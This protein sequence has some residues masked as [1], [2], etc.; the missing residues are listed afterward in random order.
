MEKGVE[1]KVLELHKNENAEFRTGQTVPH[2]SPNIRESCMLSVEGEVVGFYLKETP[3]DLKVLC[4]L[5]ND[6]FRSKDVP[7][8]QLKRTDVLAKKIKYNTDY[9]TSLKMGTVQLSTIIGL[10]PPRPL[11][12]RLKAAPSRVHFHK[13]AKTYIKA[14]MML[15]QE[16]EKV[17]KELMPKQYEKQVEII[18]E[19]TPEGLGFLD[20]FTSNIANY[21]IAAPFHR[22]TG[23]LKH[24]VNAIVTKRHN[25]SGGNLYV[26]E[27]DACFEQADRSLLVYPAWRNVHGVTKINIQK[28]NAYRNSFIFYPVAGLL[29]DYSVEKKEEES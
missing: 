8:T 25:A 9:A 27:Y 14:M 6:Q 20:M 18:K 16:C 11:F 15:G 5:V 28:E 22:D 7:K 10:M 23:N 13:K 26:P 12:K 1:M 29:R 17:I 24:T 21:N 2:K 3:K 19:N 4:N